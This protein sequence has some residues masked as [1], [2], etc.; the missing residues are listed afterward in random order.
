MISAKSI[1]ATVVAALLATRIHQPSTTTAPTSAPGFG[2]IA[3]REV[4]E[5]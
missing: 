1:D 4:M 5:G 2:A 3:M